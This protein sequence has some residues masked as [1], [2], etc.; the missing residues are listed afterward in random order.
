MKRLLIIGCSARK[1]PAPKPVIAWNLYDGP[2]FQVVKAWS[3]R[4]LSIAGFDV[5]ILSARYGLISP[6]LVIPTY[7]QRMTQERA[8]ELR[9]EVRADLQMV[10]PPGYYGEVFLMLGKDYLE[11]IGPLDVFGKAR[12]IIPPGGI[13]EKLGALRRWLMEP[14]EFDGQGIA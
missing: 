13:G 3:R 2:A 4:T 12:V 5:R 8:R 10:C 14:R 11:A 1:N 7:D 6:L 9:D